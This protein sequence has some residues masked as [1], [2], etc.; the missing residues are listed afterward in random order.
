[1]HR[2][3]IPEFTDYFFKG[4]LAQLTVNCEERNCDCKQERAGKE[5]R[6]MVGQEL[7]KYVATGRNRM[8][9]E[10]QVLMKFSLIQPTWKI[11]RATAST[12]IQELSKTKGMVTHEKKKLI[13]KSWI[14]EVMSYDDASDEYS[15]TSDALHVHLFLAS[16]SWEE[17]IG[18][19]VQGL[20][21]PLCFEMAG[22]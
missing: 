9:N 4:R 7:I 13:R 2:T 21:H 11:Q 8:M 22:T 1:M 19:A 15:M 10:F 5:K 3:C 17:P 18:L 20:P 6:E 14:Q 12:C 16:W